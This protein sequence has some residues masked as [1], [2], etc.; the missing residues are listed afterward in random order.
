MRVEN[1]PPRSLQ[2]LLSPLNTLV[3]REHYGSLA[4]WALDDLDV[5]TAYRRVKSFEV[6]SVDA[7]AHFQALFRPPQRQRPAYAESVDPDLIV[8]SSGVRSIAGLRFFALD[9]LIGQGQIEARNSSAPPVLCCIR[10]F[11]FKTQ[12]VTKWSHSVI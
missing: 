7:E 1:R 4:P 3:L 9:L 10:L 8:G 11:D 12:R 2:E 5:R 6:R